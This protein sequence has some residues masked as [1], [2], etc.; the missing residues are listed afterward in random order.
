[1]SVD[2]TPCGAIEYYPDA[3][4][5]DITDG[6]FNCVRGSVY[7]GPALQQAP[8]Q[9]P[10]VTGAVTYFPRAKGFTIS[11]GN[12]M[13]IGGNLYDTRLPKGPRDVH[14]ACE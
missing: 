4:D 3:R 8:Q 6:E 5:F 14:D 10:R 2:T 1:M 12:F 9:T 13:T 7:I 11:G